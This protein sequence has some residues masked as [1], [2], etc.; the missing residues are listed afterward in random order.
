MGA[1]A[2]LAVFA[3]LP[4]AEYVGLLAGPLTMRLT[5]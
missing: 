1:A 2:R 4:A 5:P 3:A